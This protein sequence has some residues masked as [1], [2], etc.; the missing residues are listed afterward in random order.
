MQ[1]LTRSKSISGV[2]KQLACDDNVEGAHWSV[3]GLEEGGRLPA[4][5]EAAT[6]AAKTGATAETRLPRQDHAFPIRQLISCTNYF[7]PLIADA[8]AFSSK[9]YISRAPMTPNLTY[10]IIAISPTPELYNRN[11]LL[12]PHQIMQ[13]GSPADDTRRSLPSTSVQVLIAALH[14]VKHKGKTINTSN[15][16]T[17]PSFCEYIA[18][19]AP[20][21]AL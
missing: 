15:A 11:V 20:S 21:S 12:L 8:Q 18:S 17:R 14:N 10:Y 1:G 19:L 9:R 2:D 5:V 13:N 7:R 16:L 4:R 6:E 3:M